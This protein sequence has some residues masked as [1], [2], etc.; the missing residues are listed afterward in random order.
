MLRKSAVLLFLILAVA[1]PRAQSEKLDYAAIGEIRDEGLNRSEV[2]DHAF[3]L[4]D[5][6]GPRLT[7]S[8][9]MLAASDWAMKRLSDWGLANVHREEW[10]FGPGWSLVRFSAHLLEPEVQPL[11]GFPKAWSVGTGG[12]VSADVMRVAID[13]EADFAKYRGRLKGKILLTQPARA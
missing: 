13:N 9:Q 3:W 10:D 7:G 6:F 8:P 5:R 2:M 1:F 12:P 11:V 4:S